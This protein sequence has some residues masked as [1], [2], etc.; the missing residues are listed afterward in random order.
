MLR[1]RG[2]LSWP[3]GPPATHPGRLARHQRPRRRSAGG[4]CA[5]LGP[6]PGQ[7]AAPTAVR[8]SLEEAFFLVHALRALR[9]LAAEPCAGG[10]AELT[11]EVAPALI[12]CM[13]VPVLSW[14]LCLHRM[15]TTEPAVS[16]LGESATAAAPVPAVHVLPACSACI[17]VRQTYPF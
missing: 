7:D 2:T 15:R 12:Q 9:V 3:L 14:P 11:T 13:S 8:L 5:G 10:L 4:R 17:L 1:E 6:G 16:G